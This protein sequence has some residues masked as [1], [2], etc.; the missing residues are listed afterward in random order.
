PALGNIVFGEDCDVDAEG[1]I[2]VADRGGN[3]VEVFSSDGV[4]ARSISVTAPVSVAA[5]GE[6]EVAVATLREPHLVLVFDKNGHDV[7]DFGDPEQISDREDLN[8]FLNIGDLETDATGRLF[9][10]FAYTPEPTVRQYDRYGYSAGPDIQY[11]AVE[12]ASEAQAVR[13]EI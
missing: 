5:L 6:G 13:R 4:M 10:G 7:R 3:A 8:R 9:Y 11:T 2:Y 12:A 1:R